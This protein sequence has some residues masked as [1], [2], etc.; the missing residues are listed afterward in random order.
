M[1][2]IEIEIEAQGNKKQRRIISQII[3]NDISL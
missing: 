2:K 3:Q 1:S